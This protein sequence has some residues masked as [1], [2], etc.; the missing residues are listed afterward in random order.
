MKEV[1]LTVVRPTPSTGEKKFF[2]PATIGRDKEPVV[3]KDNDDGTS[4]VPIKVM[5]EPRTNRYYC[6]FPTESHS[7]KIEKLIGKANVFVRGDC[8]SIS[9]KGYGRV[10]LKT[11]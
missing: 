7:S 2:I 4:Y 5:G 11:K 1:T 9:P 8:I 10:V 3:I 6:T